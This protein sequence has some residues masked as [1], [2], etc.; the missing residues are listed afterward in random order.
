[1]KPLRRLKKSVITGIGVVI[2]A[3]TAALLCYLFQGRQGGA[4]A[5]LIFLPIVIIVAMR[6]GLPAGAIGSVLAAFIFAVFLYQPLGS[7]SVANRT[8][9]M[10][11]AWLVLGG[12]ACSYLL[13]P[14]STNP[15]HHR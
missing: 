5:P 3:W 4:L 11:L 13:A 9:R 6:F 14:A 15:Q 8:A 7:V 1:M 2:C 12:L 10:N